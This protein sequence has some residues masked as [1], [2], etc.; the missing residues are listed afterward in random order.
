MTET[1]NMEECVNGIRACAICPAEV[2]TPIL[3]R[4]PVPPSAEDRAR[5]LQPDD[6]GE[7]IRFVAEMPAHA[8]INQIIISPTWNRLYA[9]GL[10]KPKT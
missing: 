1:I 6:L 9:G 3:D 2:A 7:T 4:R 5:M 8:C 10:E